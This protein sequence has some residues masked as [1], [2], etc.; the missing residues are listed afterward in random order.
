[1][2]MEAMEAEVALEVRS[3]VTV[4]LPR[5]DAFRLFTD[6]IGSWW[7]L[8]MHSVFQA[9]AV[10]ATMEPRVGGRVYESTADGRTSDW[11]TIT[12]WRPGERLAMTWHPGYEAELA[13]LVEVT[14]SEGPDGGT[15]VDLLHTGWEVHGA[16]A[17]EQ[18]ADYQDGWVP[19]L[20]GFAKA[21]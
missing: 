2:V 13:T 17:A 14:F 20:E 11:G 15:Q 3:S 8:A 16:E 18:A 7:P 4:K 1:M 6:R 21:A 19:V 5:D 12:E 9:E 10:T